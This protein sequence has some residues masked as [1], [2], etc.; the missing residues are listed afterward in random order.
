MTIR[1]KTFLVITSVLVALTAC[2]LVIA[3]ALGFVRLHK[4]EHEQAVARTRR[5]LL[6]LDGEI[7]ALDEVA[8]DY[9]GWD[10]TYDFMADRNEKYIQVNMTDEMSANNRF[11]FIV[12]ADKLGHILFSRAYDVARRQTAPVPQGLLDLLTPDSILFRHTESESAV[13]GV[14]NLPEGAFVVA[15]RPILTSK[16]EGPIR[17]AFLIGRR[18]AAE[19]LERVAEV[20][21]P[22]YPLLPASDPRLPADLRQTATRTLDAPP[23]SV[24]AEQRDAMTGYGLIRDVLGNPLALRVLIPRAMYAAAVRFFVFFGLILFAVC[25][26]AVAVTLVLMD[27]LVLA[28]TSRLHD[29]VNAVRSQGDLSARISLSGNDELTDL[30]NAF[31]RMLAVLDL[32]IAQRKRAEEERRQSEERYRSV[33]ETAPLAF[34]LWDRDH[35]VTDWNKLAE[36][37][38]GWSRDE[39]LGRNMFEFL[40]PS[41]DR[42]KVEEVVGKVLRGEL[43]SHSINRNLTKSGRT[44]L[45]EW[46]NA[47]QRD[48]SGMIVGAISLALDIT[49]R[50]RMEEE[51]RKL[52]TQIQQTQKLESLGVLA[53]GIAHDFNNLL[54]AILGNADLALAKLPPESPVRDAIREI[55]KGSRRAADLCQQMLAYSGRGRFVI[56]PL[57]L[58]RVVREMAYM[59]EVSVSKKAILR[60]NFAQNLPAVEADA[61]QVR[62]VVMNLIINASE[63]IGDRSGVI[64]VTTGCVECDE[65]FL[66][67]S[68]LGEKLP[69]GVYV[70]LEVADTGCGMTEE[71]KARIFDPFFT[72]KFTGRGLGLAA[73]LGI[74]RGHKG[75]V[76]VYSEQGRGSTFK[77]MFPA[78]NKVAVLKEQE[79]KQLEWRGTGTMLVVDD[80]PTVRTLA[81]KMVEWCGFK[82][83]TAD[84]GRQALEMFREHLNEIDCVILDLTMPH[85]DGEETFAELRRIKDNVRV[86]VSSGYNEQD[87]AHRFAGKGVSGFIQKPYTR[88][89]LIAVLQKVMGG[90]KTG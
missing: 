63:A 34:V 84:D 72:T 40:I 28:R 35:R 77:V 44:I 64:A 16:Y 38:F 66:R 88:E 42:S 21:L 79:A 57:D 47:V 61:T 36:A 85:M 56:E 5:A 25:V 9:A 50:S 67:G 78:S 20:N 39:V 1:R 23:V 8:N 62:Q 22:P 73:V 49:E 43:P 90:Q 10:D 68:Y 4:S 82:V 32:D 46:N 3:G 86:I 30:G 7:M 26:T 13:R 75:A 41:S 17:G 48:S 51:R 31:N 37:I 70:F 81:K 52:E 53:G 45:C 69:A 76:R 80:D 74:V 19:S 65:T 58:T 24:C 87:I 18:L 33:Y 2:I 29:F 55:E 83:M 15:S 11:A 12:L 6:A 27:R 71:T 59:L 89:P 54:M 60:Y 14:L